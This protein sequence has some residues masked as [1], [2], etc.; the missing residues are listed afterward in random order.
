MRIEELNENH[1]IVNEKHMI[2]AFDINIK[3]TVI[4]GLYYYLQ[5]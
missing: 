4:F 3:I 2:Y 1:D 5:L